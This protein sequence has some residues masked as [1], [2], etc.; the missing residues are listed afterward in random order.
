[1]KTLLLTGGIGS[2]KS[3][4]ASI[5]RERGI[6]VYDSDAR[7]KA[8]YTPWRVRRIEQI[9]GVKVHGKGGSLYRKALAAVVF[10]DP[11]ALQKLEDY[12]YPSLLRDFRQWLKVKDAPVAVFESAIA[13]SKPQFQ[14][15][16]DEVILVTAPLDLRLSRAAARDGVALETVRKRAV[17][18]D[19]PE[20]AD[21]VIVNDGTREELEARVENDLLKKIDYICKIN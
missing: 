21:Y 13:L 10:N 18:Q 4:V 6:P 7:A 8:L 5:L 20:K 17:V 12:L 3:V 1:M 2:G 11:S 9:L 16:W 15:L 14:G 19:I